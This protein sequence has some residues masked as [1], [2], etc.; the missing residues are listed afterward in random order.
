MAVYLKHVNIH[1]PQCHHHCPLLHKAEKVEVEA[2]AEAVAEVAG[3]AEA[4]R[5]RLNQSN[6]GKMWD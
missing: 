6:L 2:E 5:E 1:H 3:V 4:E